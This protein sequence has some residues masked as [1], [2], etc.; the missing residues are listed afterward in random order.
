MAGVAS[1]AILVLVPLT[2]QP[3]AAEAAPTRKNTCFFPPTVRFVANFSRF[4]T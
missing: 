3:I 4:H 2:H 1:A